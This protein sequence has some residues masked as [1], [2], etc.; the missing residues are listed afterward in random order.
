MGTATHYLETL[1]RE[2]EE[3]YRELAQQ[4]ADGKTPTAGEMTTLILA[5][6]NRTVED[7]WADVEW[8]QR[9][10]QARQQLKDAQ[11]MQA[12]INL[13]RET[14]EWAEAEFKAVRERCDRQIQE[15]AEKAGAATRE[16]K[17][18]LESVASEIRDA[19]RVLNE[20]N[21]RWKSLTPPVVVQHVGRP[22]VQDLEREIGG[23]LRAIG[24]MR[25]SV[26]KH[27]EELQREE[28]NP[29]LT[30]LGKAQELQTR[31]DGLKRTIA[32]REAKV[33]E[34]EAEIIRQTQEM[35]RSSGGTPCNTDVLR[36][37]IRRRISRNAR[38]P[39]PEPEP[40]AEAVSGAAP[41]A[42]TSASEA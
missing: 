3:R 28:R 24:E 39:D 26:D 42:V 33:L 41:E 34:N 19:Q 27:R 6:A 32:R 36:E 35:Q 15:A 11:A 22:F 30:R 1:S 8:L 17:A 37:S 5:G 38:W 21:P 10:A 18:L 14:S 25:A 23:D 31:I 20:E 4:I 7:L 16:H 40:A 9:Q 13:L 2:T 12:K 29:S